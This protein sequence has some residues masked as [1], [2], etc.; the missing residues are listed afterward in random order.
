MLYRLS[1]RARASTDLAAFSSRQLVTLLWSYAKLKLPPPEDALPEWRAAVLA[2]VEK[3][4]LLA[5]DRRN[6]LA[7]LSVFEEDPDQWLPVP[8]NQS[9]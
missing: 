9:E 3:R 1:E 4:P 2:A 5:A 7:A 6:L 8:Q